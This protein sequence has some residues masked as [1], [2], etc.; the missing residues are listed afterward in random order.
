MTGK[1]TFPAI[2]FTKP[3]VYHYTVRELAPEATDANAHWR[4][5]TQEYRVIVTVEDDGAGNLTAKADYPDGKIEFTNEYY[6]EHYNPCKCFNSLSFPMF[7][8]SPL[9]KEEFNQLMK[10]DKHFFEQ[11]EKVLEQLGRNY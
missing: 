5:D 7:L 10:K 4:I 6:N 2:S 9:Q 11:W 3:G 8:F 1:I